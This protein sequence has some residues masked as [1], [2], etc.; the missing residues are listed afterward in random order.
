MGR[1]DAL[2][3]PQT[4]CLNEKVLKYLLLHFNRIWFLPIDN[5]LNPGCASLVRRFSFIDGLIASLYGS[6]EEVHYASMYASE[7]TVWDDRLKKLMATYESLV[8]DGI[9]CPLSDV[10]FENPSAEHPLKGAVDSDLTDAEFLTLCQRQKHA[11]PIVPPDIGGEFKGGGMAMRSFL[12]P[13]EHRPAAMCSERINSALYLADVHSL[14]PVSSDRLFMRLFGTKLKR[15]LTNPEFIRERDIGSHAR[16]L[17]LNMLSWEIFVEAIPDEAISQRPF[18][19]IVLYRLE[20]KDLH[21]RFW[22]YVS[23]LETQI[24]A[25]PGT[26]ALEREVERLVQGT[27]LPAM[28][29]L[30]SSRVELWEKLFG[31]IVDK[32]AKKWKVASLALGMSL[33]PSLSYT[34]LLWYGTSGAGIALADLATPIAE[35]LIERRRLRRSALFFLVNLR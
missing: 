18:T 35:L 15:I 32:S 14:A 27:V 2:F 26:R 33:I 21:D 28:K 13:S 24:A 10:R 7:P 17:R 1:F 29:Q 11:R 22:T 8:E 6:A 19:D 25:A 5:Q 34:E 31:K 23:S 9:C 12:Y 4:I 16:E 30:E 3:Y 20:S